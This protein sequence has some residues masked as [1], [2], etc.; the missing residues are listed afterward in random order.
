M[1]EIIIPLAVLSGLLIW[2]G[3]SEKWMPELEFFT[4]EE[5]GPYWRLMDHGLLV[6]LDAFRKALGY[7]V[8]ISPASGAI[9]RPVLI[10]GKAVNA[11]DA[12]SNTW[13]NWV[14]RGRVMA[15]DL[16][17]M[18]PGGATPAERRRWFEV[19]KQVGFTGIGIYPHWE[20]RPG[21]H[22]DVRTDRPEGQ[23]ATWAGIPGPDGVQTY[24]GIERGFA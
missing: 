6:K 17:P 20:P 21:I 7:P 9:G 16:M 24:F 5:F 8:M 12:N 19:A 13:H 18:P 15:V 11:E 10:D 14:K 2:W 4:P 3:Q 23:P 22:V 1:T